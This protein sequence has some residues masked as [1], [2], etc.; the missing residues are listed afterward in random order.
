V[1]REGDFTGAE[2]ETPEALVWV[3]P[4]EPPD[5]DGLLARLRGAA[6]HGRANRLSAGHRD[7]PEI[8]AVSIATHWPAGEPLAARAPTSLP[9]LELVSREPV[10][11]LIRHRRSAQAFDGVSGLAAPAFFRMLDALLPRAGQPPW[12][13]LESVPQVHPVLFVHR[14]EG[15]DAG[16]YCLAR[17]P[18]QLGLLKAE[19]R[20]DWLWA[21]VPGCPPH[22]PLYLLA[23]QDLRDFAAAVSCQQDIAS[24]S[25]FSLAMLARFDDMAPNR[26]WLYRQRFWEAGILGQALY[27]E[28]EA[29]GVRGTGIGCYFDDAVHR[30]LG[31]EGT[32]LQDIY[33]FTVGTAVTDRRLA[34]EPPYAHLRDRLASAVSAGDG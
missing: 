21:P 7:W 2:R 27:L 13:L 4:G 23:A 14:V 8:D 28:A 10:S 1:D 18:D 29:A 24:D 12:S 26:P 9:P 5:A 32:R 15:L 34:S 20:R 19:L 16:L 6:W 3:G 33:H 22:L 30:A 11:R 31:L 17:D 25:A